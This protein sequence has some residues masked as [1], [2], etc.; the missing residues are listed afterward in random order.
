MAKGPDVQ[1]AHVGIYVA[2]IRKMAAFYTRFF[3]F[4]VT[5]RGT[6]GETELVFLS[7]DPDEHHQLVL[8]SGRPLPLGFNVVN[9]ISFRV[10]SL[11]DLRTLH[12]RLADEPVTEIRP[13]SHGN[14]WSVYFRDPEGNRI[15]L[16][17]D[18]PWYISQPFREPLDLSQPDEAIL[19]ETERLCRASPGFRPHAEWRAEV[20]RRMGVTH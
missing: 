6:L 3:N 11:D 17:L 8:A 5:D 16:Y 12:A 7:R 1:L 2:D 20:A 15:E 18:T 10:A 13:V 9:Q 19:R 14:A 4:T